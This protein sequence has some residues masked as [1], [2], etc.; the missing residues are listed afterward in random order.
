MIELWKRH[1]AWRFARHAQPQMAAERTP[2][3][4]ITAF[5]GPSVDGG[6]ARTLSSKKGSHGMTEDIDPNDTDPRPL[7]VAFN[8]EETRRTL[9]IA[10][11]FASY[12]H[13]HGEPVPADP[14]RALLGA[15]ELMARRLEILN[16]VNEREQWQADGGVVH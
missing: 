7:P 6:G 2:E 13:A 11:W 12:C 15:A 4:P 14:M 9:K 10:E 3:G 5:I 1:V 8:A 16:T